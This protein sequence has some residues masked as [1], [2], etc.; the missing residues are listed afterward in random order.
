MEYPCYQC[1]ASVEEGVAFCPNCNAP[2]IRVAGSEEKPATPPLPPGTPDEI[3][4][5]ARPAELHPNATWDRGSRPGIPL[6]AESIQWSEALPGA[7]LAGLAIALSWIIPL[8][9]FLLWPIAAGAFAV[10]LYLRRRP[11]TAVTAGMGARVGAI[12]GLF[13]FVIFAVLMAI[14]LMVLR[15][16]GRLR[17]AMEQ[18]IQQSAAR[19]PNPQAQAMIRRLLSPEG[20]AV[21]ITVVLIFFLAAFVACGS[22]GGALG[23]ALFKK[24]RGD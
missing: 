11:Q 21:M 4:P 14:D 12:T 3:Q 20:V 23:A 1:G 18:V 24:R 19:N 15:G 22:I 9:A 5:P 13:G 6:R 2:Q 16:G 10:A 17:Q 8:A 7:L